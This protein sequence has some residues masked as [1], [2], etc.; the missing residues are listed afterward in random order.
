M[1]HRPFFSSQTHLSP[2]VILKVEKYKG[3]ERVIHIGVRPLP[4]FSP[5]MA[6]PSISI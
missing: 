3:V 5:V 1:E 4:T 6:H 2:Q